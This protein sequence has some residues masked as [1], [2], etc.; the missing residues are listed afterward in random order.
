MITACCARAL[1]KGTGRPYMSFLCICYVVRSL[2]TTRNQFLHNCDCHAADGTTPAARF[3]RRS[4]LAL[5]ETGLSPIEALPRP[6]QRKH[7]MALNHRRHEYVPLY[8]DTPEVGVELSP[9]YS[10]P[11]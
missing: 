4:F 8:V 3:C 1:Q 6:R 7:H 10:I 2:E 9:G 5:F 11:L